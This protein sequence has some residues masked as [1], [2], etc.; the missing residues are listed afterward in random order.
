[1][2]DLLPV[3]F[4][5]FIL[6]RGGFPGL[7]R[8][9]SYRKVSLGKKRADREQAMLDLTSVVAQ[10][11]ETGLEPSMYQSPTVSETDSP[12]PSIWCKLCRAWLTCPWTWL[13]VGSHGLTWVFLCDVT[14]P[15]GRGLSFLGHP[16]TASEDLWD[17]PSFSESFYWRGNHPVKATG[18]KFKPQDLRFKSDILLKQPLKHYFLQDRFKTRYF[19]CL[20]I[21]QAQKKKEETLKKTNQGKRG[22]WMSI[23]FNSHF[24]MLNFLLCEIMCL[25]H[26]SLIKVSQINE[27]HSSHVSSF[28]DSLPQFTIPE[29][30][31]FILYFTHLILATS[32]IYFFVCGLP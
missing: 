7:W 9:E 6:H 16:H 1:M 28:P 18:S 19:L 13:A 15:R 23:S 20:K 5:L 25:T 29:L 17:A 4:F 32:I 21:C 22:L 2:P 27:Y 3:S 14:L 24:E 26:W 10:K 12:H 31:Y 11:S 30:Q 8:D